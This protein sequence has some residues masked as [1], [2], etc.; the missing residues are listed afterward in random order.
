MASELKDLSAQNFE[1]NK[2]NCQ[3]LWR[4]SENDNKFMASMLET[5]DRKLKAFEGRVD[6]LEGRVEALHAGHARTVSELSELQQQQAK[7]EEQLALTN[8]SHISRRD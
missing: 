1:D 4:K 8:K 7:F 2:N 6:V 5:M 3:K